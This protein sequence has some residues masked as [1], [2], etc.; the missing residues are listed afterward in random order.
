MRIYLDCCCYNRPFD[1]QSN[2]TIAFETTAKMLV[3]QWVMEEQVE[4]VDSFVLRE[5]LS[6]ITNEQKLGIIYQFIDDNANVFIASD[7]AAEVLALAGDIMSEGI[8]YMDASHLACAIVSKANYFLTTDKRI[9]KYKGSLI[10]VINPIDF[11]RMQEE[12]NDEL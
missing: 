9:L 2:R 11:V 12:Q 10:N 7:K 1:M 8:K 5:E 3:Q 4:L 6:G